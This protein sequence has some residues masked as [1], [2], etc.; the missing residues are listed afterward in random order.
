[1][2]SFWASVTDHGRG[3]CLLC[4]AWPRERPHCGRLSHGKREAHHL[5]PKQ[6]LRREYPFGGVVQ[7]ETNCLRRAERRVEYP[8]PLFV[9]LEELLTDAANGVCLGSWHHAQVENRRCAIPRGM[10]G[11]RAEEFAEAVKLEHVLDRL[12]GMVAFA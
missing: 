11:L 8:A 7:A 5:V 3:E 9:S 1:M 10:L 2:A 6:Q 12:Y 4:R